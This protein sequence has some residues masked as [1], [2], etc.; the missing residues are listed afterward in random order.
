MLKQRAILGCSNEEKTAVYFLEPKL[1]LVPIWVTKVFLIQN[2]HNDLLNTSSEIN[3]IRHQYYVAAFH[4]V[5][6]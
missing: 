3:I 2:N 6:P 5:T 4:N 1:Q